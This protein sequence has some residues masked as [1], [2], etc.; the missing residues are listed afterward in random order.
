MVIFSKDELSTLRF[1]IYRLLLKKQKL[2]FHNDTIATNQKLTDDFMTMFTPVSTTINASYLSRYTIGILSNNYNDIS[3]S[4]LNRIIALD[5]QVFMSGNVPEKF[6]QHDHVHAPGRLDFTEYM[7]HA[8]SCD[9][10][11]GLSDREDC[12][13]LVG[14]EFLF[15]NKKV[16]VS[17]TKANRD[18]YSDFV[19]YLSSSDT[20]SVIQ[21]KIAKALN[22]GSTASSYQQIYKE[23]CQ[24][25]YSRYNVFVS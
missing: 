1:N 22:S 3:E 14:R 13:V 19:E 5:F 10:I 7:E 25:Q 23:T 12:L 21:L 16:I 4:L 11:V 18:H 8:L 6:K 9:V 20:E 2:V 17:D 15:Y 24:N